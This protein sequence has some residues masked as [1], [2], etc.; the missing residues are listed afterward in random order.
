MTKKTLRS[1]AFYPENPPIEATR[2]WDNLGEFSEIVNELYVNDAR[3]EIL[4]KRNVTS[5]ADAKDFNDKCE[6][7]IR[8][9]Y[10]I[11]KDAAVEGYTEAIASEKRA[12]AN[13][14]NEVRA[15]HEDEIAKLENR[16]KEV[17]RY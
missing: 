16:L 9:Y 11:F 4:W 3:F 17:N 7:A 2:M 6:S 14:I 13:E 8:A 10:K 5:E 1:D 12:R 15:K